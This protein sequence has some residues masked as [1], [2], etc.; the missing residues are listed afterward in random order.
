VRSS[1]KLSVPFYHQEHE[2]TCG[3]AC[4]RMVLELF[5]TTLTESELEARCGTTLLGTGRTEL[6]QA[7]KS[8]GFAAE[9]ADHLTREDVET[10]LSQGR[11]LIAVLDPS[12][13]YP[14]VPASRTASSS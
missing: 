13:L 2:H 1:V 5:G 8:L 9:L 12:L 14:G 7:A 4:L 3:P 10:Y 11:P 6:A